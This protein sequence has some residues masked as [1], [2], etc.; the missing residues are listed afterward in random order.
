[1]GLVAQ[2]A[3]APAWR[4]VGGSAVDLR[5]AAPATGPV[6]RVWFSEDGT[7][8][9]A[10]TPSNQVF[11]TVDFETWQPAG[12][13]AEPTPPPVVTA[14]RVPEPGATLLA[15]NSRSPRIF[16]AGRQLW[17]SG[18][19]GQTWLNL[20][21]YKGSA[22]VGPGQTSV[23][24]SPADEKQVVLAND[25]GVWR[26]MDGGLSW[27]GL[28]R[29]LPNLKI[30]RI[31]STPTGAT[32]TR[33]LTD[34]LGALELPP[35]GSVWAPT[36]APEI[37][38]E[39]R[40]MG[41]YSVPL[42]TPITALGAA[43]GTV[44]AGSAD[45][46]MWVSVDGGSTFHQSRPTNASGQ[47]ERIFVYQ[48]ADQTEPWVALAVLSGKGPRV[49]LTTNSGSTWDSLDGNLPDTPVH[50]ITAD[51]AAG[52]VYVAT[53]KGVFYTQTDLQ[54]STPN[55]VWTSLSEG[56]QA[57]AANDVRLDPV[58]VQL[59]AALDGYGIYAT[60]APHRTRN[61][62]I[63]NTADYSTRAAAP[64][65]LLSVV[66]AHVNAVRGGDLNYPVLAAAD[67]ESQIQVPFEAQGP[68]VS[69][70]LD[71]TG[72][73]VTR[74]VAVQPVSPAI[75]VGRDGVPMLWDADSGLPL[76][77]RN[78]AHSNGRVQIWATGLGKVRPDWPTG[79]A[80]PLESPPEV[81]AQVRALLDGTPLQVL[82][83][84]LVPGYIGFYL[85]EVQLPPINN[86]GPSQLYIAA[87]GQ[88]SNRVQVI[89]EP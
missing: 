54:N 35:G 81:V 85:V 14:P 46:R 87:G 66:G 36:G 37:E 17:G 30:E 71:T 75:L 18:D 28:N 3:P 77:A 78:T 20:T 74:G 52:A 82:K 89:L 45:G 33:V 10:R 83:A 2:I 22:V 63:V 5:L 68:S 70:Q 86:L 47:V 23:A 19:G 44:Y 42:G 84:T 15:A 31:L 26:S 29:L 4:R 12:D 11:R 7:A 50:G 38:A 24:V 72:G 65:S 57:A 60:R 40:A 27:D 62:R 79:M 8:L 25:F 6:S 55:V 21:A 43:G 13:V 64:G 61:L 39:K 16:A 48:T 80:A 51:W 32:G 73:M 1:M 67:A 9:Y 69:L 53:G 34:R 41:G 56:L 76:D 49:L 88:E 59:Y 58:G